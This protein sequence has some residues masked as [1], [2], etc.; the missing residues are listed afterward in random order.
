MILDVSQLYSFGTNSLEN[1]KS[2]NTHSGIEIEQIG[3]C[4][5]VRLSGFLDHNLGEK[6]LESFNEEIMSA[7]NKNIIVDMSQIEYI[8]SSGLGALVALQ[9]SIKRNDGSLVLSNLQGTGL[10]VMK[11]SQLLKIFHFCDTTE[12]ALEELKN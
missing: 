6:L 1:Q 7:Q 5:V 11:S 8:D 10:D 4:Q 9:L 2:L 3:E 12:G